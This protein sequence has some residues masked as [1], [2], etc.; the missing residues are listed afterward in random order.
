MILDIY[1]GLFQRIYIFPPSIDVDFQA[2]QP[3]KTY[4]EK[5]LKIT[6]RR[7]T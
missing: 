2:W 6:N 7:R 3:V 5:D 4:I 1:K